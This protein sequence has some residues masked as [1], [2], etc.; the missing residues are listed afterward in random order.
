MMIYM[1]KEICGTNVLTGA[2]LI[3]H[4]YDW[5]FHIKGGGHIQL[6]MFRAIRKRGT[7]MSC[8]ES[9]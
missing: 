9:E 3:D 6:S 4:S 5:C 1:Q 8:D 7:I 2:L